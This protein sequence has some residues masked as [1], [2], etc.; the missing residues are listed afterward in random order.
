MMKRIDAIMDTVAGA[1]KE[2]ALRKLGIH[3]REMEKAIVC[4]KRE[5]EWP[6]NFF[7]MNFF[8]ILRTIL[9]PGSPNILRAS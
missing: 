8:K 1:K 9:F 2:E 4:D 5:L 3:I 7:R 6:T